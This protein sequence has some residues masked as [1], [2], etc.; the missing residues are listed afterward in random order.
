MKKSLCYFLLL[1]CGLW[2]C[3]NFEEVS[4]IQFKANFNAPFVARAGEEIKF[5]P[6]I[7]TTG[8][9]RFEWDFG[10]RENTSTQA[11]PTFVYDSIGSYQVKLNVE[12]EKT[13][14]IVKDSLKRL[15]HII[16]PTIPFTGDKFVKSWTT[17]DLLED[18]VAFGMTEAADGSY[19][20][21]ARRGLNGLSVLKTNAA[22][23]GIEPNWGGI[24]DDLGSGLIFP[25]AIIRTTANKYVIVGYIQ[26]TV[27]DNDAF[28]LQ[29]DDLG[30]EEWR[31]TEINAN[32]DEQYNSVVEMPDGNYFVTGVTTS[33][34]K[35]VI[36]T[37]IYS[38]LGDI[39][40]FNSID[41]S[42][43]SSCRINKMQATAD[44][45]YLLIGTKLNRPL[46]LKLNADLSFFG[47]FELGNTGKALNTIQLSDGKYIMTGE[48]R[49]AANLDST[50]AF[51]AKFDDL[52][53]TD[54]NIYWGFALVLYQES[55]S[56]VIENRATK[57]VT[58]VGNHR[59]PL[60]KDDFLLAQYDSEQGELQKIRLAG[61]I[62]PERITQVIQKTDGDIIIVG[63]MRSSSVD[64]F[65]RTDLIFIQVK[66]SVF[67]AD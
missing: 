6:G 16:P 54:G 40:N 37:H 38:P 4:Y 25:Q 58:I 12:I 2:A 9:Q 62:Q 61:D 56:Q 49:N 32:F 1:S 11:R 48:L 52:S 26:K 66:P 39:L 30:N 14:G 65:S 60:S 46:A 15:I 44:G 20:V 19:I 33:A 41:K 29:L 47:D 17:G 51:I 67:F 36:P 45:G 53:F 63:T 55:Y 35:A 7:T 22:F 21:I 8:A 43:C 3:K 42:I 31:E 5:E 28:I 64:E 23:D 57:Q 10:D 34:G 18:E 24:F 13:T 50:N 27:S 59:N